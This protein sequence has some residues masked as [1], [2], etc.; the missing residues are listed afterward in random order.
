MI[1]LKKNEIVQKFSDHTKRVG[2]VIASAHS[3]KKSCN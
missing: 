3:K 2:F 1:Y